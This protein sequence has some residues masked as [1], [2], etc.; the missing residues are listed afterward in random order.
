MS[1]LKNEIACLKAEVVELKAALDLANKKLDISTSA[2]VRTST[3]NVA[4]N[5]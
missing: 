5:G 4:E 1:E 2:E 3:R